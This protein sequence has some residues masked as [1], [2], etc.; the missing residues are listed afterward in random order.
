[1]FKSKTTVKRELDKKIRRLLTNN[2]GEFTSDN[3]FS[4]C[5][6]NGI[7]R[8]LIYVEIPQ[9]NDVAKRKIRHVVE[10]YKRWLHTKIL[11]NYLWAKGI[12]CVEYMINCMSLSPINL[13]MPF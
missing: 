12:K 13:K 11:P 2:G 8:E 1:M 4:F 10:T 3:F 6:Q 9:Q 7:K 5:Q